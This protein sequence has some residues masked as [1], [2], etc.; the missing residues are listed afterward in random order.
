MSVQPPTLVDIHMKRGIRPEFD[1]YIGRQMTYPPS[2]RDTFP[3][4][5]KWHNPFTFKEYGEAALTMYGIYI[6]KILGIMQMPYLFS[7]PGLTEFHF[8]VIAGKLEES[9][10]R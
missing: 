10:E 1:T 5:S 8:Q 4:D 3:E 9:R 2:I 6:K 7:Y